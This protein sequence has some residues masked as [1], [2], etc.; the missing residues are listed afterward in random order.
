MKIL[1]FLMEWFIQFHCG[2]ISMND[3]KCITYNEATTDRINKI[4]DIV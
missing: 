3:A 1:L 4:L 2:H